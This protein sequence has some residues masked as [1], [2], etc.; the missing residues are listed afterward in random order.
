MKANFNFLLLFSVIMFSFCSKNNQKAPENPSTPVQ[1]SNITG[2]WVNATTT[3]TLVMFDWMYATNKTVFGM[4]LSSS[5]Y[6]SVDNGATWS[7]PSN[8]LSGVSCITQSN[9]T[10][11]LSLISGGGFFKST[12]EGN[13]WIPTTSS[14]SNLAISSIACGT[15]GVFVSTNNGIYKSTDGGN[16]WIHAGFTNTFVNHIAILK[17]KI[18]AA[19]YTDGL[20]VS[21]NSGLNWTQCS[22]GIFGASIDCIALVGNNVLVSTEIGT[23]I[24]SNGGVNWNSVDSL[25]SFCKISSY[26]SRAIALSNSNGKKKVFL[27]KNNGID[28]VN[29]T[30]GLPFIP[31]YG[32]IAINDKYV[33]LNAYSMNKI[34]RKPF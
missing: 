24:S 1:P 17:D 30:I 27:T 3:G 6:R 29:D 19:T 8:P 26:G 15:I 7:N 16:N 2:P 12:D 34:F 9:T 21:S 32:G 22:G 14:F 20:F 18:F 10:L 13:T 5:I 11:F 25:S 31:S 4:Y 23:Y 28:W 33:Y